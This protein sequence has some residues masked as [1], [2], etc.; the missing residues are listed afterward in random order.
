MYK[1]EIVQYMIIVRYVQIWDVFMKWIVGNL[2]Y[3][4]MYKI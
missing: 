1:T 4:N 3:G 2:N